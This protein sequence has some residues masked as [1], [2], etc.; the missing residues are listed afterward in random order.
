MVVSSFTEATSNLG[1]ASFCVDTCAVAGT[2]KHTTN[3]SNPRQTLG[4]MTTKVYHLGLTGS[5]TKP[6][7]QDC[8]S[9][10]SQY[11]RIFCAS[12]SAVVT[13]FWLLAES[14]EGDYTKVCSGADAKLVM[15]QEPDQPET[16]T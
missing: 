6:R 5:I 13:R 8:G 12:R 3:A 1:S 7:R 14:M 11:I 16:A 10:H 4:S 9:R 15:I 2:A